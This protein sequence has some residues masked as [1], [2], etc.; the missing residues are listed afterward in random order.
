MMAVDETAVDDDDGTSKI[1]AGVR[2][3]GVFDCLSRFISDSDLHGST[4]VG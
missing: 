1:G 4:F 2:A 3:G